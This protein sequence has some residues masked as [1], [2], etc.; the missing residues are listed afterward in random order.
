[1][2]SVNVLAKHK[3]FKR[4]RQDD[5][6]SFREENAPKETCPRSGILY[7]THDKACHLPRVFVSKTEFNR[8]LS[9]LARAAVIYKTFVCPNTTRDVLDGAFYGTF[10]K[11]VVLNEGLERLGWRN[12]KEYHKGTFCNSQIR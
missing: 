9:Q 12:D 3:I 6:N 10:Q 5:N 1:M 7:K 8:G 2:D 4:A 11:L